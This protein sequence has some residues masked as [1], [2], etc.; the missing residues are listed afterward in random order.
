[1]CFRLFGGTIFTSF[2]IQHE[3]TPTFSWVLR[4]RGFP[5]SF[6]HRSRC[7]R[8]DAVVHGVLYVARVFVLV[9][10]IVRS[11][12]INVVLLCIRVL[13]Y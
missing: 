10:P 12:S 3:A 13:R 9:A 2:V 1:M 5:L 6:L 11:T 7:A 8:E 4:S